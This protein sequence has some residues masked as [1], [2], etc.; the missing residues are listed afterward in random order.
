MFVFC[1]QYMGQA[2]LH[3]FDEWCGST[4]DSLRNNVHFPLHPHIRTTVKALAVAPQQINYGLRIFGYLHPPA[5]GEYVFALSSH[6]NSELWLSSDQSPLNLLLRAWVGKTGAEW[7]A[8]GEYDKFLHQTSTSIRLSNQT[9][10][11]FEVILKQNNQGTDHVVVAVIV[12]S[13]H[14]LLFCSTDESSLMIGDIAHIPQTA[15]SHERNNVQK[16]NSAPDMQR[17]DPRDT[18]YQVPMINSTLL[19]GLLPDCVYKPSYTINGYK[20]ERYQ[21]LD[22]VHLS[23]IYPNDHTRLT[24]LDTETTCYYRINP[25]EQVNSK[26]VNSK[27]TRE[28]KP[29][30]TEVHIEDKVDAVEP[31]ELGD[32]SLDQ[33]DWEEPIVQS[34]PVEANS[35][36]KTKWTQTFKINNL[37]YQ[38]QQSHAL[39]MKC[40]LTGN[41]QIQEAEVQAIVEAYMDKFNQTHRGW[42]LERMVNVVMNVDVRNGKR[43]LLELEVREESGVLLRLSQYIYALKSTPSPPEKQLKLCNPV[44]FRWTPEAVVHFVIP[45][46]NQARWVHLLIRDVENLVKDTGDLNFNL[47]LTDFKST[48]MNIEEALAKSKIPRYQYKKLNGNFERSRGLQEGINLIKDPHSIV[49]LFDLHIRFPSSI[50]DLIRKHCVEGY[51]TFA[52]SSCGLWE[53]Q[54]FGLLG[55]Y[56]SDLDRVG[57]MNTREFKDRWGGEDWE[58]LDR[59]L[60]GGLEV[61]RFYMRNF[62]HHFHTKR[63]MWMSNHS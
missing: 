47:I 56:K 4:T 36:E 13:R 59:I 52:P 6:D 5:D 55:I 60:E 61:E 46:K 33:W 8:P 38:G 54:G 3:V 29:P 58:L 16:P 50:I 39:N 22:Y 49:F 27:K 62:Y 43:Y 57:G 15:A 35:N 18:F 19:S 10:Y 63:G 40:R 31:S 14:F 2:N 37:G 17:E 51:Q 34:M 42:T 25:L 20:L 12:E 21:G 9:R 7:T 26:K 41:I 45:V 28:R 30:K 32:L 48:D 44:G 24:H 11:F 53:V 1:L 23:Y